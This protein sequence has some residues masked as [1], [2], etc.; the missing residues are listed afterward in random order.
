[1][2]STSPPTPISL[3]F[4]SVRIPL[5]VESID[6]PNPFNTF[7]TLSFFTY[8]LKPGLLTLFIPDITPFLDE[9]YLSWIL[10]I[11]CLLSFIN[12]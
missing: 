2:Q 1:M 12:S 11:P 5:D 6:R 7:A 10:I 8:F 3:A 4:L 9:S